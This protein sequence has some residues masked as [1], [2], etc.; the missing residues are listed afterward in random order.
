MKK[1]IKIT[2]AVIAVASAVIGVLVIRD[3]CY[4]KGYDDARK[5]FNDEMLNWD[6][7]EEQKYTVDDK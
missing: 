2:A 3:K 6:D 4:S 1:G 5:L 7:D